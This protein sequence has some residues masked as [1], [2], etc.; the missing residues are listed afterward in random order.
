MG[1]ISSSEASGVRLVLR[2]QRLDK[3]SQQGLGDMY[4][5]VCVE[6]GLKPPAYGL[7]M[8]TNYEDLKGAGIMMRFDIFPGS[9]VSLDAL[10][11]MIETTILRY[12]TPARS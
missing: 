11:Q 4:E 9:V 12:L 3:M 8:N 1:I 2:D 6:L 7:V 5:Y 10:V